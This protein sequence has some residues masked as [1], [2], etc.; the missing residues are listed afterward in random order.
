[1]TDVLFSCRAIGRYGRA[2]LTAVNAKGVTFHMGKIDRT[3]V[4]PQTGCR[5]PAQFAAPCK[6]RR[7]YKLADAA[8]L[9][10][11]GANLLQLDPGVW[12]SQR[13]WHTHEDE[14][15][16]VLSGEVLLVTD[17]GEQILRAGDCAGFKAG[18]R[19]GHCLRNASAKMAEILVVGSR[20]DADSGEYS[21]IDMKFAPGRYSGAV[22]YLH[23][24]GKPY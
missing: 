23:K 5:Y 17:A 24:D 1:M 2:V 6:Q 16:Y 4:A 13:H 3:A 11:F 7:W 9:H 8:G 21:D 22:A 20:I 18:L 14:F 12:S 10:Q 15:I 19:D